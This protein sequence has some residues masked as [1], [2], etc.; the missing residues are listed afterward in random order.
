MGTFKIGNVTLG[1]KVF[2]ANGNRYVLAPDIS[3]A[4]DIMKQLRINV[5]TLSLY[6][7]LNESCSLV[8]RLGSTVT[9][10]K[11]GELLVMD[12]VLV[13]GSPRGLNTTCPNKVVYTR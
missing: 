4:K 13:F 10:Q 1:D 12:T 6:T 7:T 5:E 8:H 9:T 11:S 3:M 2:C